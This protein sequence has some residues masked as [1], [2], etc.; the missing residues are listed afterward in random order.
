MLPSTGCTLIGRMSNK[1]CVA[2]SVVKLTRTG[3]IIN[4]RIYSGK[5]NKIA[6]R[7][8]FEINFVLV[9]E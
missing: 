1:Q 3:K 7:F 6:A 4:N 9:S 5:N 8:V 2:F